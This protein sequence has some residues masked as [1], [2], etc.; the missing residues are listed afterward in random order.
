MP[1]TMIV[2][3][4]LLL[5]GAPFFYRILD[6]YFGLTWVSCSQLRRV[7]LNLVIR[8]PVISRN[9][10]INLNTATIKRTENIRNLYEVRESRRTITIHH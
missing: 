5:Y 4:H 8:F 2:M 7:D 1:S 10:E 3:N 6:V 9:I